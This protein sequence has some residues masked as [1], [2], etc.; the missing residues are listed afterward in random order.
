M[1]IRFKLLLAALVAFLA[2]LLV[3]FALWMPL[4]LQQARNDFVRN[5]DMILAAME[6]DLVRHL[7]AHDYA[8]MYSSLDQQ[9]QRQQVS[10]RALSLHL[11]NGRRLYPLFA[12]QDAVLPTPSTQLALEHPIAL[13]GGR[14]HVCLFRLTGS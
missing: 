10:W 1:R 4:Q 5:Q 7:L 2:Y 11:A 12:E 6:S 9:L 8:A 13:G 14:L 3:M